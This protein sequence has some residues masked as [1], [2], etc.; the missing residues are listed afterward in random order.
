MNWVEALNYCDQLIPGAHLASAGSSPENTFISQLYIE[1]SRHKYVWLGG[2]D[3][4]VEGNW[5]WTD[6]TTFSF[7]NW[8]SGEGNDGAT[9]NCL[10]MDVYWSGYW[11][12]F[13]C[14]DALWSICEVDLEKQD[15]K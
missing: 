4:S 7:T 15:N 12:D 10:A 1:Q 3:S 11:S 13:G 5:T 9:H 6:G 2:T 14:F 8:G